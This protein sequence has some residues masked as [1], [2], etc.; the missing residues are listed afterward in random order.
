MTPL[1]TSGCA[2]FHG[3][4]G[5]LITVRENTVIYVQT[6]MFW[7]QKCPESGIELGV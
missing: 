5:F 6:S 2:E 3:A 1:S 7:Y 4:V